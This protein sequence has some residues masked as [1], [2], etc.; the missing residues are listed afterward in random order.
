MLEGKDDY[1]NLKLVYRDFAE[2]V[3]ASA[4]TVTETTLGDDQDVSHN[5]SFWGGGD[6]MFVSE[7]LGLG[8]RFSSKGHN[9]CWCEVHSDHL[10]S[11]KTSTPRTLTR[12][13]NLAHLPSPLMV[14]DGVMTPFECP[15]CNMKFESMQVNHERDVAQVSW[16]DIER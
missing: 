13:Y 11:P 7:V 5:V 14:V 4:V 12:L 8:G 16:W 6:M 9:C 3:R 15:G 2:A 10:S 1:N